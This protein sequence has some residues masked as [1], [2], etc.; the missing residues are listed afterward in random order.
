V[1]DIFEKIT[2]YDILFFLPHEESDS[3]VK[4][5][6]ALYKIR[7]EPLDIHCEGIHHSFDIVLFRMDEEEMVDLERFQGVLTEPRE[8]VSRMI[9][10]DFYGM[11]ARKTT[12]SAQVVQDAFDSWSKF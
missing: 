8:Y 11:V 3:K 7:G 6:S 9:K 12:T 10:S 4:V 5:E 1:L 2:D